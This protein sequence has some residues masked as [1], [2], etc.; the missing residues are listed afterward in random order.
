MIAIDYY[1]KLEKM[2]NKDFSY[3]Y[4]ILDLIYKSNLNSEQRKNKI[5]KI[6]EKL[7]KKE[8]IMK[9]K[10]PPILFN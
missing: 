8:N 6:K 4:F 2:I 5:S 7:L 9:L 3:V 1:K 10:K